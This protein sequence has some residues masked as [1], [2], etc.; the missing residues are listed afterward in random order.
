MQGNPYKFSIISLN[1]TMSFLYV[2]IDDYK[3]LTLSR[4]C[5][6]AVLTLT[7][8]MSIFSYVVQGNPHKI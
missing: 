6:E 4:I 5:C 7:L 8:E 2:E 1:E 3:I